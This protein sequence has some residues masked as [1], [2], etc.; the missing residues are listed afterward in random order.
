MIDEED[1][2]VTVGGKSLVQ[3]KSVGTNNSGKSFGNKKK[4]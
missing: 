3:K 2:D 1:K 4:T